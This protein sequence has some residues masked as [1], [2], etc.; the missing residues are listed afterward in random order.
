MNG[1]M[2]IDVRN[3]TLHTHIFMTCLRQYLFTIV[4]LK[5]LLLEVL[6]DPLGSSLESR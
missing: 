2:C 1:Y 4:V 3:D 6:F 5:W